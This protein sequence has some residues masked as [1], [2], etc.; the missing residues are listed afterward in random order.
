MHSKIFL[1]MVVVLVLCMGMGCGGG[2]NS[3]GSFSYPIAGSWQLVSTTLPVAANKIV[4]NSDGTGSFLVGASSG[5]LTW[6]VAGSDL[7]TINFPPPT[8]SQTYKLT[9]IDSNTIIVQ[10]TSGGGTINYIRG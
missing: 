5:S 8:G 10:S 9:W 7:L 2:S 3:G 6:S 1:F 4:F